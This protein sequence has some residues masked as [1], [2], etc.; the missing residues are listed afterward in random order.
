MSTATTITMM[1]SRPA[2]AMIL[3]PARFAPWPRF[4]VT[5]GRHLLGTAATCP[6]R[7]NVAGVSA[8]HAV[9]VV[10]GS[11]W[12]IEAFDPKTW[13]NEG[14]VQRS[15]LAVGDQLTVGPCTWRVR[16]AST[17]DLLANVAP[18]VPPVV[19]KGSTAKRTS[20][21]SHAKP[22]ASLQ[23][24]SLTRPSM[25]ARAAAPALVTCA[26]DSKVG[27]LESPAGNDTAMVVGE[28]PPLSAPPAVMEEV[29]PLA[30]EEKGEDVLTEQQGLNASQPV[31]EATPAADVPSSGMPLELLETMQ[32]WLTSAGASIA[33]GEGPAFRQPLVSPPPAM[34]PTPGPR[35]EELVRLLDE[36]QTLRR[37]LESARSVWR[38]ETAQRE[39]QLASESTGLARREA[40]LERSEHELQRQQSE[41]E[42]TRHVLNEREESL[43]STEASLRTLQTELENERTRLETVARET[44]QQFDA[45]C[46]RQAAAW[47]EWQLT[48]QRL[49]EAITQQETELEERRSLLQNDRE[50]LQQEHRELEVDR[51]DFEV[52]RAQEEQEQAEWQQARAAWERQKATQ[53]RA[54]A[55]AMLHIQQQQERLA[56]EVRERAH[57]QS[58]LLNAQ[59]QLQ[60][61]RRLLSEQQTAWLQEREAA[62]VDLAERRQ[63]L[64]HETDQLDLARREIERLHTTL[65][66]ELQGVQQRS[67]ELAAATERATAAEEQAL[68]QVAELAAARSVTANELVESEPRASADE[69]AADSAQEEKSA[70]PSAD[71]E[72]VQEAL[73]ALAARFEEFAV[74]EERLA[75]KHDILRELQQDL[76]AREAEIRQQQESLEAQRSVWQAEQEAW[77]ARVVQQNEQ[78]LA[79]ER[80]QAEDHQQRAWEQQR[81]ADQLE[82]LQLLLDQKVEQSKT[83]SL[84]PAV[85]LATTVIHVT[86]TGGSP[87]PDE[88]R[89]VVEAAAES[90]AL[91]HQDHPDAGDQQAGLVSAPL[92]EETSHRNRSVIRELADD[93][94]AIEPP[95]IVMGLEEASADSSPE[96]PVTSADQVA[97]SRTEESSLPETSLEKPGDNLA[98]PDPEATVSDDQF[99]RRSLLSEIELPLNSPAHA[100]PESM[101]DPVAGMVIETSSP[102][103]GDDV[104]N[105][106]LEEV[107]FGNRWLQPREFYSLSEGAESTPREKGTDSAAAGESS[108]RAELARMFN[109]PEN[110]ST[111]TPSPVQET[112]EAESVEDAPSPPEISMESSELEETP[113]E[114]ESWRSRLSE[115][116]RTPPASPPAPEVSVQ[117][118]AVESDHEAPALT[119]D[120][121]VASYMERLLARTRKATSGGSGESEPEPRTPAIQRSVRTEVPVPE[122]W[123]GEASE[124]PTTFETRRTIDKDATRAE[125]QSFREVANRS[126]RAALAR[127]TWQTM[128][129]EL[130][131]QAILTGLCTAGSVAYLGGPFWGQPIQ[132]GPGLGC[133]VGAVFIGYRAWMNWNRLGRWNRDNENEPSLPG[134]EQLAAELLDR[135]YQP[136]SS[137]VETESPAT[138]VGS[139]PVSR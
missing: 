122:E 66:Q 62:W 100:I 17:D 101:E 97:S 8:E 128:R 3:E 32:S 78:Q 68:A 2:Q 102:S 74:L 131:I 12:R 75:T 19:P 123:T 15:Q 16:A 23:A 38:D 76:T 13:I 104:V 60:Q 95:L 22:A 39:L 10:S 35:V 125:L 115:L 120:D 24:P 55:E 85:D 82:Q 18:D 139:P 117:A 105:M 51:R 112:R 124:R 45:E 103:R 70:P 21:A 42:R 96:I 9:L 33:S 108:L 80:Q 127:H 111:A 135:T 58:D 30:R 11:E 114:E 90:V 132:L 110:F 37:D 31:K 98:P 41:L 25:A 133:T 61:D 64:D 86:E 34:P 126:A 134:P 26:R 56:G 44:Q 1:A 83:V 130:S 49:L 6:L 116:M 20:A 54:H 27:S 48:Q 46:Q 65:E 119:E 106:S 36:L 118:E 29:S 89:P 77:Q 99:W 88:T 53:E 109:L 84:P 73:T 72:A 94:A 28:F 79:R 63:R 67:A 4:L 71:F 5:P 50:F 129:T 137:S 69:A 14:P 52:Q 87:S 47:T 113:A 59:Q 93:S 91:P 57:Q 40:A 7:V 138:V 43:R 136:R 121:S 92:W 81:W 107:V